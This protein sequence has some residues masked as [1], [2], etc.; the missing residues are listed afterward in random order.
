MNPRK[1]IFREVQSRLAAGESKLDVYNALKTRF[2]APSVERSLAQWP[3]PAAKKQN[4]SMNVPLIIIAVFFAL[5][6]ILSAA[7]VIDKL[8]PAQV[9]NVAIIL[10]IQLYTIYGVI[11]C[12]LIGYMLL[13]LISIRNILMIVPG[14]ISDPKLGMVLAMSAAAI[15][16]SV[17]QKRKL[18]PNTSWFLRHKRDSSGA[19]IF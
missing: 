19:P 17:I 16:L 15:L 3:L 10:I 12:N 5:L 14:G 11:N 6:T 4:Q 7:P 2:H 18:F 9:A 1:H 8:A 13:I